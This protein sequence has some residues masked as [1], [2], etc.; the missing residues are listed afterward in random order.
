MSRVSPAGALSTIW[1]P[2][3]GTS[4]FAYTGFGPS[5]CMPP[6]WYTYWEKLVGYYSP[7]ICPSGFEPGCTRYGTPTGTALDQGPTEVA[8]ETAWLCVVSGFSCAPALSYKSYATS[9]SVTLAMIQIRWKSSDLSILETHP[10]TPGLK[11]VATTTTPTPSRSSPTGTTGPSPTRSESRSSPIAPK[12]SPTSPLPV[13]D[14]DSSG[15]STAAKAGIG[16]GVGAAVL[17]LCIAIIIFI[18]RHRS[19]HLYQPAE[20]QVEVRDPS[21]IEAV[22]AKASDKTTVMPFNSAASPQNS[23]PEVISLP[24]RQ[25]MNCH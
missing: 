7:A 15:L 16:A 23:S 1:T 11:F 12:P 21:P 2:P 25:S 3:C 5:T 10:L 9:G 24:L 20:M 8:G 18:R 6:N 14:I 17:L 19:N 22:V 13:N 4:A